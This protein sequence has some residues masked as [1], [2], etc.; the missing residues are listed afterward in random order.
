MY[1]CSTSAKLGYPTCTTW[2][3]SLASPTLFFP[4]I[5]GGVKK[6]GLVSLKNLPLAKA[7]L[8]HLLAL[9]NLCL[10]SGRG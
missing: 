8:H 3:C 1:C 5:V 7:W 10:K 6:S 4:L 2:K 9:Q